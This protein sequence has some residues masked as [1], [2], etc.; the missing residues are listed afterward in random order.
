M[1][2]IGVFSLTIAMAD[3]RKPKMADDEWI[4]T[5]SEGIRMVR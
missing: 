1:K 3:R 2:R 4:R 5:Q